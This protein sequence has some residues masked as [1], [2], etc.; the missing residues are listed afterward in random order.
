MSKNIVIQEGGIGKQLTVDKLKTNIVGGG[1]CLWVPEDETQ[2][3]T[4][5]ISEN[6]TYKASTDGY[7][8]YSEVTVSG[9]GTATGKDGDGD[10]AT[11]TPDPDTGDLVTTKIIESIAVVNPPTVTSY[12]D[13][14]AIDF[15]GLSVHGYST[16]G[17]DLGEIPISDLIFPETQAD[18]SKGSGQGEVTV[19]GLNSPVYLNAVS[20]GTYLEPERLVPGPIGEINTAHYISNMNGNAYIFV[21]DNSAS[22]IVY[23]FVSTEYFNLM[24]QRQCP[25]GWDPQI[26]T[27]RGS[28]Q[29][30]QGHTAYVAGA[31]QTSAENTVFPIS[32]K[33]DIG[34]REAAI[35]AITTGVPVEGVTQAIPI[36]YINSQGQTLETSFNIQVSAP[37]A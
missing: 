24:T 36:Q 21:A 13:G 14:A 31:I 27:Y 2:L 23:C 33:Q 12:Q 4:K 15:T 28:Q 1:S 22:T 34:V 37:S 19:E 11:V 10:E 5:Y 32:A 17:K 3:G 9:I 20:E 18:Y 25:P 30:Y 8:G 6:G 35:L 29:T 26:A 16:T 7:Y